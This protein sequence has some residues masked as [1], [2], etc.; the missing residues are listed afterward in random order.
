MAEGETLSDVDYF[1]P[2][3][4]ELVASIL[5]QSEE[6]EFGLIALTEVLQGES[7][8]ELSAFLLHLDTR[9]G[10]VHS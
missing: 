6:T 2:S 5:S 1:I 3:T 9:Q 4:A 8:P 10:F 7:G